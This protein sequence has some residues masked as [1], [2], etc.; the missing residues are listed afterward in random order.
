MGEIRGGITVETMVEMTVKTMA[1]MI[2]M[3]GVA[4]WFV[5]GARGEEMMHGGANADAAD[6][7]VNHRVRYSH[8]AA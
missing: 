3:E 6:E 5:G 1:V 8:Q 2:M 4:Q 7:S